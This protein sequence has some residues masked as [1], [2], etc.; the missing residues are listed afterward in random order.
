M[1]GTCLYCGREAKRSKGTLC[2]AH[3]YR[4]RRTGSP[5]D[6]PIVD[7]RQGCSVEGCD[8]EHRGRG[9][10]SKHLQ[11]VKAHGTTDLP[12]PPSGESHYNWGGSEI[13]YN[14]AHQRVRKHRGKASDHVCECGDGAEHWA[15]IHEACELVEQDMPYSA[16]VNNYKPMCVSCHKAY[17]LKR[18]EAKQ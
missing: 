7:G 11:R 12:E 13:T 5:G 14:G 16:D 4:I 3:Y 18:K 1:I 17:D 6:Y 15:A 8:G 2:E 9:L 10:C